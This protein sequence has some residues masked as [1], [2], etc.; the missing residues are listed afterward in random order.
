MKK[1]FIIDQLTKSQTIDPNSINRLYKINKILKFMEIRSKN[2]RMTQNQVCKQLGTSDSSIKRYGDD[3]HL[4]SPYN[5]NK[6]GKKK[7][8]SLST[9]TQTQS[10]RANKTPKII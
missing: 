5:I 1:N 8:K 9:V 7:I 10:Q 6:Y 3:I 4:D 2:P